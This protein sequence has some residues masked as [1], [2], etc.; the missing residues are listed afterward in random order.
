MTFSERQG[1]VTK[2]TEFQIDNINAELK[3]RLWNIIDKQIVQVFTKE[4]SLAEYLP[5]N[6]TDFIDDV[7]DKFFKKNTDYKPNYPY[8]EFRNR[9]FSLE[10]FKLYDFFEFIIKLNN[11]YINT[12][13][14]IENTNIVLKEEFAGY[15]IISGYVTPITSAIEIN[16]L[17]QTLNISENYPQYKGLDIH[18]NEAISKLADKKNPDYRNSI[19][20]SISSIETLCRQLTNESTLG[21]AINKLESSGLQINGELKKGIEKFY[22]Y[23]NNKESGI[24]HAIIDEFKEPTFADAKY[25]LVM[26]S[27]F[28]NFLIAKINE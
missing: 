13:K 11:P 26:S 24:R 16:E 5:Q 20:E 4:F 28:I 18:I 2:R 10:W 19:K 9:V 12:K 14:L 15:Q 21:K 27:A 17:N 23:T 1:I 7:N 22:N 25:I 8:T 6:S 3:N